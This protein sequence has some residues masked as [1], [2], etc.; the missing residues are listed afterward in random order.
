VREDLAVLGEP[1]TEGR[2]I[3]RRLGAVLGAIEGLDG[4]AEARRLEA[5]LVERCT[6]VSAAA[7]R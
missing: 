1:V 3:V 4:L 2:R 7:V 6:S 5:P